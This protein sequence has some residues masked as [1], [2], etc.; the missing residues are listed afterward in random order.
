VTANFLGFWPVSA[1]VEKNITGSPYAQHVI[2]GGVEVQF[3]TGGG[4]VTTRNVFLSSYSAYG[5]Y[6][7]LVN[8]YDETLT[9]KK[10]GVTC[11]RGQ[12]CSTVPTPYITNIALPTVPVGFA[13]GENQAVAFLCSLTAQEKGQGGEVKFETSLGDVVVPFTCAPDIG[14]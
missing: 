14:A 11:G 13:C 4:Q 12:D 1:Q 3:P 5:V 8:G 2:A 9:L 10:A 7:G 6:V